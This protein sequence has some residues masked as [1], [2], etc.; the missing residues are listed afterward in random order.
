MNLLFAD[1]PTFIEKDRVLKNHCERVDRDPDTIT[2]SL[3]AYVFITPHGQ[4]PAPRSG[5][6]YI[7]YGTP[8]QVAD[9]LAGFIEAGVQH[10]MIRFLD[11]PSTE[12]LEL[13]QNKVLPHVSINS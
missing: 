4:K 9:Q 12:G 7:I 1:L 2:R 13:F 5:N 10:F 11:F 3:Y 8:D 6:K